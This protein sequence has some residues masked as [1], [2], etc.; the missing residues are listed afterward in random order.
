MK[1]D[2]S[3]YPFELTISEVEDESISGT[4]VWPT[5]NNAKTRIRGTW[6]RSTQKITFEEYQVIRGEDDVEVPMKYEGSLLE[7]ENTIQGHNVTE[8][9]ELQSTFVLSC[10]K[11]EEEEP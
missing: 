1:T 11:E 6:K 8:T 9:K 7:D 10:K 4:I 5:L 2:K 3:Q